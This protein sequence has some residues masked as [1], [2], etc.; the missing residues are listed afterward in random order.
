MVGT[1]FVNNHDVAFM[2]PDST[3]RR[4]M[5]SAQ[6]LGR[7]RGEACI[8]TTPSGVGTLHQ[9]QEPLHLR[10]SLAWHVLAVQKGRL[11]SS[12]S[13]TACIIDVFRV[14]RAFARYEGSM[15]AIAHGQ[16]KLADM[17]IRDRA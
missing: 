14:S 3:L 4:R 1:S 10:A 13:G 9:A 16:N 11:G 8:V 17:R 2:K 7:R 12:A 15:M 6:S 5:R